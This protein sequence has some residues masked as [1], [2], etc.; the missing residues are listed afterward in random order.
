[1]HIECLRQKSCEKER[2]INRQ[3]DKHLDRQ[4][5][6]Q[7]DRCDGNR[8]IKYRQI[9]I[10]RENEGYFAKLQLKAYDETK[11]YFVTYRVVKELYNKPEN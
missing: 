7:T 1:M 8:Q 10:E 2:E 4:I 11:L 9:E 5:D 6:R 3:V